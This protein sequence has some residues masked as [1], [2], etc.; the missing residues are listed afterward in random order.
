MSFRRRNYQE[1]MD[2][3]LTGI[4]GGQA[5][6]PHAFPP[7]DGSSPYGYALAM[8]PVADLVSVW[9]SR[10]GEPHQ[11]RKDTDYGLD[12]DGRSLV[13]LEGGEW[14]D[15][16]SLFQVNYL[17][18]GTAAAVNDIHVG[19]VLRT[20]AETVGLEIARLYAQLEGVYRS[21]YLDTA[22]GSAL[23]KVVSLLG[24]E[25]VRAGRFSGELQLS[26]TPGSHGEIHVPAGTRVLTIDGN[27][28]YE[29]V[30]A[31]TL[32]EGQSTAQV[33][34]RDRETNPQGVAPDQLVILAK[35]IAGIQSV[36]NPA[37]TT[38]AGADE[39]DAQ[40][41]T[42]TKAFLHG[43]ERA[44]VG[45]LKEALSHQGVPV[46]V[47][48][49]TEGG[50]ANGRVRLTPHAEAMTPEL[51][52]RLETVKD[53]VRPLGVDVRFDAAVVPKKLDL[54][55]RLTT[56]ADLLEQ[57]LRAAQ[58]AVR[59][60]IGDYLQ[61]L[62]VA[63]GGSTNRLVGLILGVPEISDVQIL[64]A[65]VQ[66]EAPPAG[67]PGLE[68]LGLAGAATTL[69]ELELID[70]NLPTRLQVFVTYPET[71]PPP[72]PA[73]M[74]TALNALTTYLAAANA[75]DPPA[76]ASLDYRALLYLLP[77]PVAGKTTGVPQDLYGGTPP[78]LPTAAEVSPYQP[79]FVLTMQSGLARVL[80]Q[81]GDGYDLSPDER[82]S[83]AGVEVDLEEAVDA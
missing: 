67:P 13:W 9:G 3:L 75:A 36:T 28:E 70:P 44:T 62:A 6:E 17:P 79:R 76:V 29:T 71:A 37:A 58:N 46:D 81:D 31:A 61:N 59:T 11:F 10:N 60:R 26:R 5:A 1:V 52:Q 19:S 22:E 2:G 47:A 65:A 25:R 49:L 63:E 78:T 51:M 64:S 55:L 48:E 73:A 35:P 56:G 15:E 53:Q 38:A 20:L 66:G 42:R 7:S 4:L 24:V 54:S 23:D 77:L 16:G 30:A 72:A 34:A 43:S 45:A 33:Q 69:G 32:L 80:E 8:A 12:G 83:L 21:A 14:P 57:D 27:I 50:F 41:R 82:L 39:T 68:S 18:T 40:L 74:T